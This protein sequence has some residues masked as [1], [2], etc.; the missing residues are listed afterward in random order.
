MSLYD[1][2][3]RSWRDWLP[4]LP[5][6]ALV[7]MGWRG[8][9][10]WAFGD[11]VAALLVLCLLCNPLRLLSWMASK[12]R[13]C[14]ALTVILV[15]AAVQL[16]GVGWYARLCLLLVAAVLGVLAWQRR[17]AWQHD[18]A[19]QQS[20]AVDKVLS[21]LRHG[22]KLDAA[23]AWKEHGCAET[24]ALLRQAAG[25]EAPEGLIDTAYRMVYMLGYLH[26]C[27]DGE[28]LR[29]QISQ[30]K[31]KNKEQQLEIVMQKS[32]LD[33]NG[34]QERIEYLEGQLSDAQAELST[35]YA[36]LDELKAQQP[37]PA[38]EPQTMED[39]DE[40]I[41]QLVE[42]G[43]SW[44]EAGK[45]YGLSKGGVQGALKRAKKHREENES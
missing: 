41:L 3:T 33:E 12:T 40:A 6:G 45:V 10:P 43:S 22:G 2:V 17:K 5:I 7:I 34:G 14:S 32:F 19:F 25:V 20:A 4:L 13:I 36:Q 21:Q 35:V 44:T 26:G 23:D 37:E 30:L 11:A 38:A 31:A 18:D 15:V 24:C 27:R 8:A 1:V 9:P 28:K 39:R 16:P 29:A 42:G